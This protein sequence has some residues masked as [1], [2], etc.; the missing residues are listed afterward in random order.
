MDSAYKADYHFQNLILLGK[1]LN[2]GFLS[3]SLMKFRLCL[4]L[5]QPKKG[6]NTFTKKKK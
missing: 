3:I 2:L 4:F 6:T 5:L 1:M